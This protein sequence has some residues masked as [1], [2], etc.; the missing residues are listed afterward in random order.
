MYE[1]VMFWVMLGDV[2]A[3]LVM[4][5]VILMIFLYVLWVGN[6]PADKY[7]SLQW[8]QPVPQVGKGCPTYGNDLSR[9]AEKRLNRWTL[10]IDHWTLII[11][12]WSLNIDHWTFFA[13]A[14][15]YVNIEH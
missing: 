15:Q 13:Y 10:I 8:E 5:L 4:F 14:Q 2:F 9:Q 1:L 12:H 3:V 6:R 11:E 7:V